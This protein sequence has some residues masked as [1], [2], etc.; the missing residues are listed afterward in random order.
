M[1]IAELLRPTIFTVAP[2]IDWEEPIE[3]E[4]AKNGLVDWRSFLPESVEEN[5]L[6]HILGQTGEKISDENSLVKEALFSH[7]ISPEDLE[8]YGIT[9]HTPVSIVSL[10]TENTSFVGI[11]AHDHQNREETRLVGI[12]PSTA[13]VPKTA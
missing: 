3:V 7:G 10:F 2:T 5:I 9:R 1:A 13:G 6:N 8:G 12:F 11:V 4:E